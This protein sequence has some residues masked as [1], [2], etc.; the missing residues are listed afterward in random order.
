MQAAGGVP[1]QRIGPK[2]GQ[3]ETELTGGVEVTRHAPALGDAG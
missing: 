1:S 3:G 2:R